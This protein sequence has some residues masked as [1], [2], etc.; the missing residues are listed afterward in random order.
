MKLNHIE[1]PRV[2][3]Q[4]TTQ[5]YIYSLNLI[6]DSLGIPCL[7]LDSHNRIIYVNNVFCAAN[8]VSRDEI[9]NHKITEISMPR[10]A[11]YTKFA[12]QV[13]QQHA[14]IITTNQKR[15]YLEVAKQDDS[16]T[17]TIVYKT[18]IFDL[19]TDVTQRLKIF[20]K[21]HSLL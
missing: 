15:I 4:A 17:A 2:N 6:S 13:K 5:Q 19:D 18:P 11:I 9:L 20:H 21:L 1:L 16:S 3:I 8:S 10:F 12:K 14:E 7:L